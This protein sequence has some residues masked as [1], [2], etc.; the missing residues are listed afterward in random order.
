MTASGHEMLRALGG[1]LRP[2]IAPGGVAS[3]SSAESPDFQAMLEK[4]RA[5][6]LSSG[7]R[8]TPGRGVDVEFSTEDID[9]LSAAA[10]EAEAL[11][12]ARLF[13]L[14]GED[15]FEIDVAMRRIERRVSAPDLGRV[16]TGIDAVVV[17][18]GSSAASGEEDSEV[19]RDVLT[20][21]PPTE[22]PPPASLLKTLSDAEAR[23]GMREPTDR[24]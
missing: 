5:G 16:Q 3:R 23:L 11:G 24:A 13:A 8:V 1:G 22:A 7:R 6:E 12:A 17:R 10:D 4:A 14:L 15:G 21:R 19:A 20:T 2:E 9:A 18:A